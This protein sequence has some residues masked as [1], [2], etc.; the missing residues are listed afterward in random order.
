MH[1]LAFTALDTL[2]QIEKYR[3]VRAHT[4]ALCQQLETEDYG[5]QPEVFVSPAK[6]HL[7]HSTWFFETFLLKNYLKDYQAFHPA[8]AFFFNSYYESLGQRSKRTERGFLSRPTVSEV[9]AYRRHVDSHMEQL[10]AEAAP[11]EEVFLLGLHHEQQHQELLATDL[12]YSLGFNPL[13]PAVLDLQEQSLMPTAQTYISVPEGLYEIGHTGEGFCFDNELGRHQVYLSSYKIAQRLVNNQEYL[14]FIEDGGY[15]K[16]LLWHEEGWAWV[17]QN[18]AQA[19][20][21]WQQDSQ[22]AWHFYTLQGLQKLE[23]QAPATHLNFYEAAAFAAWAGKRL[24]TEFEWE[25]A[26]AHLHYGQRWEWTQSAYLPYPGYRKQAGALGEY[27]GKF[28]VNQM[29]LRGASVATPAGHS[30]PSYRNFFHPQYQW[31][32]SGLRLA[33]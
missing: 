14:E 25:A 30:R 10:L 32:F 23:A 21:H 6:W 19:P 27:N 29:V 9:Y 18:Q 3:Q 11:P 8:Y 22:G 24:P 5:L 17:K 4:E 28:M 20:L 7:A 26:V 16:A 1:T 31:Q 2:S 13:Y 15:Q 33:E 12:K